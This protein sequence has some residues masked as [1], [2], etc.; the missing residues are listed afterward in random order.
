M[1]RMLK[2][3]AAFPLFSNLYLAQ[4]FNTLVKPLFPY[5]LVIPDL[6]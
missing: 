1:V 2:F 4:F 6:S 3:F 5:V